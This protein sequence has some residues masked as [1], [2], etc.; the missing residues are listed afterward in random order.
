MSSARPASP[1]NPCPRPCGTASRNA[2]RLLQS[3][4]VFPRG[5][6][7]HSLYLFP[8]PALGFQCRQSAILERKTGMREFVEY[9]LVMRGDDDRRPHAVQLLE[10]SHEPETD[11]VIQVS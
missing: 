1:E 10:Q 11:L 7:K 8:D 3:P 4:A 9:P 5:T 6:L 2:V